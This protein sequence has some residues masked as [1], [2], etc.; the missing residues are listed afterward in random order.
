[1]N[2]IV[3]ISTFVFY[4]IAIFYIGYIAYRNTSNIVDYLLGGRQLGRWTTALS[5]GASDMSGWLLL[6]LPGYAYAAIHM[7]SIPA[8]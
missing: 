6:G 5:A 2:N 7:A 4:F 3:L 8:A 1:M